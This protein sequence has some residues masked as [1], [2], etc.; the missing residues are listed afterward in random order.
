MVKQ[1][2]DICHKISLH[3]L[4]IGHSLANMILAQNI[5]VPTAITK[6]VLKRLYGI[7]QV[8]ATGSS[9]MSQVSQMSQIQS[10]VKYCIK[11]CLSCLGFSPAQAT[12][13]ASHFLIASSEQTVARNH[14]GGEKKKPLCKVCTT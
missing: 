12:L 3:C 1:R 5:S 13:T 14:S 11:L 9:Q 4:N 2:L 8:L 7:K 10:S 6:S